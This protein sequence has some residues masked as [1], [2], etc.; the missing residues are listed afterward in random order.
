V[1]YDAERSFFLEFRHRLRA[2]TQLIAEIEGALAAVHE[3]YDTRVWENR[4]VAG[5]V[6]EQIIGSAARAL[7]L[8]IANVGKHNQGYD[9]ELP[10]GEGLSIKA[11]FSSTDGQIRLINKLGE[12]TRIWVDATLF[13]VA[14]VGIGY[15]DPVLVPGLTA[16]SGDALVISGRQLKAFWAA[17][18][19][20]LV[21]FVNV[22]PKSSG[23][24]TSVASDVVAFDVFQRFPRL[25]GA[26]RPEI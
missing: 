16:S 6:T 12:G 19:E 9:L 10:S 21:D 15:A 23:A 22:P 11:V 25:M 18:T 1:A 7:G 17:N 4:F 5:G 8:D 3:R 14:M 20:W 2:D 26:F 13:P 24:N